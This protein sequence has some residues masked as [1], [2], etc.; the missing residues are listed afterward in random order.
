MNSKVQPKSDK[1]LQD[2]SPRVSSAT[3]ETRMAS[4]QLSDLANERSFEASEE[5]NETQTT[6]DRASGLER[7]RSQSPYYH[8]MDKA[9]QYQQGEQHS[10]NGFGS[11]GPQQILT[12]SGLWPWEGPNSSG[13]TAQDHRFLEQ[14]FQQQMQS[15]SAS[16]FV[17]GPMHPQHVHQMQNSQGSTTPFVPGLV[18]PQHA[19]QMQ[20][21]QGSTS[22][23]VPG[24]VHPQH[25]H[26]MQN[27]Q[28]RASP[29]VPGPVHSRPAHQMQ[30]SQGGTSPFVLGSVHPRHACQMENSPEISQ[31]T[32]LITET[33]HENTRYLGVPPDSS[34]GY[35]EAFFSFNPETSMMQVR[36]SS[37]PLHPQPGYQHP[38]SAMQVHSS[39][40][41][42]HPQPGYR[43]LNPASPVQGPAYTQGQAPS[44]SPQQQLSQSLGRRPPVRFMGSPP[45]GPPSPSVM[46]R[47]IPSQL[48]ST[49]SQ[50]RQRPTRPRRPYACDTCPMSFTRPSNLVTHLR[51]HSGEKPYV[52]QDCD[53]AHSTKS[54]MV[55]HRLSLHRNTLTPEE[56]EKLE[57]KLE[58]KENN[59]ARKAAAKALARQK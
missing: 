14:H 51:V 40:G 16:P 19:H 25:A 36:S 5:H 54:N 13:Y 28:G 44:H 11:R 22:P 43:H 34:P 50:Q 35:M 42:L 3:R 37:G 18:H 30:N 2:G 55:R 1:S 8:A 45:T 48:P 6:H 46:A 39:P 56:Q 24:L 7:S 4:Q 47:G 32:S 41:P 20:N 53:K 59:R 49:P 27:S 29:S 26:H 9:H 58:K 33:P 52:C 12:K 31:P 21:S 23:F 15:G 38:T 17:P 57:K 10:Q